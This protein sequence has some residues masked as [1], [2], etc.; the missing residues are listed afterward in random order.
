M[1]ERN[2]VPTEQP[3]WSTRQSKDV[4]AAARKYLKDNRIEITPLV[5]QR[6]L[7]VLGDAARRGLVLE[8]RTH[9]S[10]KDKIRPLI[11]KGLQ[12][13][14][15]LRVRAGEL[16]SLS[17]SE[18]D[19]YGDL[20]GPLAL[21]AS[22]VRAAT[23]EMSNFIVIAEPKA[24]EEVVN[25][26]NQR[27]SRI[28]HIAQTGLNHLPQPFTGV[29]LD[30]FPTVLERARLIRNMIASFVFRGNL[31]PQISTQDLK[32]FVLQSE[33]PK[34]MVSQSDTIAEIAGLTQQPDRAFLQA[35]AR[36]ASQLFISHKTLPDDDNPR[37]VDDFY[38]HFARG[39]LLLHP[40]L[41]EQSI[42]TVPYKVMKESPS[43]WDG[44]LIIEGVK[45]PRVELLAQALRQA[46]ARGDQ[47]NTERLINGIRVWKFYQ[48]ATKRHNLSIQKAETELQEREQL[49]SN[50][51]DPN[52]KLP[53]EAY[54]IVYVE[55]QKAESTFRGK[56]ADA[57]R[58]AKIIEETDTEIEG[59]EQY[60][61]Y[62][63]QRY[64]DKLPSLIPIPLKVHER[65]EDQ[66]RTKLK[67]RIITIQNQIT[68]IEDLLDFDLL[69]YR[70]SGSAIARLRRDDSKEWI[71]EQRKQ[72]QQLLEQIETDP[73]S[74]YYNEQFLKQTRSRIREITGRSARQYYPAALKDIYSFWK[75]LPQTITEILQSK[76]KEKTW[77]NLIKQILQKRLEL[78]DITTSSIAQRE[79]LTA[80]NLETNETE[81]PQ[82]STLVSE[83]E[84]WTKEDALKYMQKIRILKIPQ[85]VKLDKDQITAIRSFVL[86]LPLT[87]LPKKIIGRNTFITWVL[88]RMSVA[89]EQASIASEEVE[90]LKQSTNPDRTELAR[91]NKRIRNSEKRTKT[92]EQLLNFM[93]H[94]LFP[95]PEGAG[96]SREDFLDAWKKRMNFA[97]AICYHDE[98][99]TKSQMLQ[100]TYEQVMR[101]YFKQRLAIEIASKTKN[102]DKLKTRN[103][104]RE[105]VNSLQRLN[106]VLEE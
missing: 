12:A 26:G 73:Q 90:M 102:L 93:K 22:L 50:L 101:K 99:A 52:F 56:R 24:I 81:K 18:P 66:R 55:Q 103:I 5:F 37:S 79:R 8:G 23:I 35:L 71:E 65:A 14:E 84:Y 40:A 32:D 77:P 75:D 70:E 41:E 85:G 39:L 62:L 78:L 4:L 95:L 96:L 89:Q 63:R 64:G 29:T 15:G 47:I 69:R 67:G 13:R 91:A 49:F 97:Y 92:Y 2:L 86:T 46:E 28:D 34:D 53:K 60:E 94:E 61:Q 36:Q 30:R 80:A 11:N 7:S 25:V 16:L 27:I 76:E 57:E 82:A 43:I 20:I 104:A 44:G 100:L 6:T 87:A 83:D 88:S 105:F 10:P 1:T 72:A 98:V 3:Q 31:S 17:K 68:L 42:V 9:F 45:I 74:L 51:N 21:P 48:D 54:F 19:V 106:L 33:P 38:R 59:I 58:L